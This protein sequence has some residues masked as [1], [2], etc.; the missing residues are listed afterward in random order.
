[1]LKTAFG[2]RKFPATDETSA[3]PLVPS[4]AGNALSRHV[5]NTELRLGFWEQFK[6]NRK[7]AEVTAEKLGEITVTMVEK[8]KQEIYQKL[9]LE[10]DINKKRA[11]AGYMDQVGSLNKEL[12]EKSNQMERDLR[13]ILRDEIGQ[14]YD[15]KSAWEKQ[16]GAMN[17]SNEDMQ[18]ERE[19]LDRWIE[20]AKDQVEGKVLT[21]VETHSASL[22]VTLKLL[23]DKAIS[24]GDAINLG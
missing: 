16:L 10:L 9:M 12:T 19:R 15:E 24:G 11:Y 20:L 13:D 23:Q 7:A 1:M 2:K 17:L 5:K 6:F 14:I 4:K 22:E 18:T 8:Q 3:K 21:L